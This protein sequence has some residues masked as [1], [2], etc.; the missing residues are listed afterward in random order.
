MALERGLLVVKQVGKDKP[1]RIQVRVGKADFNP[2]QGE[3]SQSLL[4]RLVEFKGK[5]VEF[6]RVKGQPKQ[7]R[8]A[9]GSF[10]PLRRK[11]PELRPRNTKDPRGGDP[12][13]RRTEQ[14]REREEHNSPDLP[15]DFHNPYNFVPAP[16]R[17]T[18]HSDL[19]DHPAEAQDAFSL[20]RYS[21]RIRVRMTAETPFLVPDAERVRESSTGHKTYSL[22][23]GPDGK[24][25]IP[26]S[27]VRGMIR[28]AYEAITNSR[29]GR[30]SENHKQK[31]QY[32]QDRKPYRK[33]DFDASPWDLLA[34]SLRP[35]MTIAEFSPAD[36][37]FGWVKGDSQGES[38]R[39]SAAGFAAARGLLRVGSIMCE[40][41]VDEAAQIFPGAGVPLA[42]LS[43]PKPQQGR[44]YV[45]KSREGTAQR[46]G[47]N[48]IEAGYT[49]DKGLRGRKVYPHH[50]GLPDGYWDDPMREKMGAGNPAHYHEYRRPRKDDQEQLDDQN[51]SIL[52][53]VKPGTEFTFEIQVHNLSKVELGALVW[54]LKLGK[55]HFFR[56]GGGKPLGFGSVRLS[57]DDCDVRTGEGLL[58]RYEKWY[59]TTASADP[60]D[61]AIQ[62]FKQALCEAYPP[63]AGGGF[64][65][66]P[67]I[68][69]FLTA[70]RGFGDSLPV[71]YPRVT[72]NGR[73]GP[74]SPEGESFKWFVANEKGPK[75]ALRDLAE[76][77]GLPTLKEP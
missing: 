65:N 20:D 41:S 13:L 63:P 9:G 35:A 22:L 26:A 8:E 61:A 29:F 40:S 68:T 25:L 2:S 64:E 58:A 14:S 77:K 1:P 46:D 66:I 53:W 42:V 73:P 37:V 5:E 23:V 49:N 3:V 50:D 15:P 12:S 69:A 44:F 36:R 24:P 52:G 38:N 57:I 70:C 28:S 21:G 72:G 32:R 6:E 39:N 55:G 7:I 71:R 56:F 60:C 18:G 76:D 4:D 43:T 47:L 54:L 74:P 48:K 45:A 10:V 27:S 16:P 67:F 19:G 31:L 51:R 17:N 59:T 33:V 34:E 30:F 75:L 11:E 62:S